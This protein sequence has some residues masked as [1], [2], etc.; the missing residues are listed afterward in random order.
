[1][2]RHFLLFNLLTFLLVFATPTRAVLY[3]W[4]DDDGNIH[5]SDEQPSE[6]KQI[7][8]I[9]DYTATESKLSPTDT[10]LIKP[11]DK[12]VKKLLLLD[13]EYLWKK[14]SH[15][16]KSVR[17]GVFSTGT[18][19]TSVGA[20]K[21]HEIATRHSSLFPE[22][23]R[24][25]FRI[26]DV[27][28]NLGY[29]ADRTDKRL[30]E[31]DEIGLGGLILRS[32][33]IAMKF[34]TC[35]PGIKKQAIQ[36]PIEDLA[37]HRFKRHRIEL[38]ISWEL[39]SRDDKRVLYQTVTS[40]RYSAWHKLTR[41]QI[42]VEKAVESATLNLFSDSKFVDKL[43]TAEN[44]TTHTPEKP[45]TSK[46]SFAEDLVIQAHASQVLVGLSTLKI[47]VAQYFLINNE[48]PISLYDMNL[49]ENMFRDSRTISRV[50]FK[51]DGSI[52][53]ELRELFGAG[54]TLSMTP[55]QDALETG[56]MRW[57]CSSNLPMN[58]MGS[59]FAT[60]HPK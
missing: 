54:K 13:T 42:A 29:A 56:L 7:T 48:W 34:H 51:S 4:V 52:V 41:S 50:G 23:Y 43:F 45:V 55:S 37:L 16:S 53:A 9:I 21:S 24:L 33:I 18:G 36:R 6:A 35:A 15:K 2:E 59:L 47:H 46:P 57:S 30:L 44:I 25:A 22:E 8:T 10:P 11:Y 14:P 32:T 19:C 40:G 12:Y 20:I 17:L 5:Y 60:C 27:V 49:S 28:Q 3:K 39:R 31:I 38:K 1:M 26:K 58:Y